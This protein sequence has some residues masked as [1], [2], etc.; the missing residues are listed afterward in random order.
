ME[1]QLYDTN[2]INRNVNYQKISSLVFD[3]IYDTYNII[4][5]CKKFKK[6]YFYCKYR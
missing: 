5:L 3:I 4:I 2:K 6:L 1:V